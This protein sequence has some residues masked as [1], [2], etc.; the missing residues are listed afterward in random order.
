MTLTLSVRAPLS[1]ASWHEALT[2]TACE[3]RD[4]SLYGDFTA[5]PIMCGLAIGTGMVQCSYVSCGKPACSMARQVSRSGRHPS[6]RRRHRGLT[7]CLETPQPGAL[8]RCHMLDEHE[9]PPGFST[10]KTS[11]RARC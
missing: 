3:G 7:H 11:W 10:R 1:G 4:C 9:S 8:R 5:T 6:P 2:P